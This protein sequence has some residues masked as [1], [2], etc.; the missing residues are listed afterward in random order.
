MKTFDQKHLLGTE[1]LTK[2]EIMDIM[3][4]A[5]K[6]KDLT[7]KGHHVVPTLH[8]KIVILMFF[9]PST[10]TRSSFEI[11]AKRLGAERDAEDIKKHKFFKRIDWDAVYRRE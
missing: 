10:R 3:N 6:F 11:A 1:G 2:D 5:K 4:T 8:G 7:N 9:E